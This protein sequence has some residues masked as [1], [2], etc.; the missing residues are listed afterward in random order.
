MRTILRRLF[1]VVA[2]ALLSFAVLEGGWRGARA[3]SCAAYGDKGRG[4][5][6]IY[7]LNEGLPYPVSFTAMVAGQFGPEIGGRPVKVVDVAL[8]AIY[9][10]AEALE[11][12]VECHDPAVPGAVASHSSTPPPPR[13]VEPPAP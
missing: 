7:G 11:R 6:E 10:R 12:A 1:I 13:D 4:S 3:L 8:G 2:G 9:P 5:F